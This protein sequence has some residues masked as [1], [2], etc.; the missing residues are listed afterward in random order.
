MIGTDHENIA[1]IFIIL[2]QFVICRYLGE[3]ILLYLEYIF[4]MYSWILTLAMEYNPKVRNKSC[5]H[6]LTCLRAQ[7]NKEIADPP[8]PTAEIEIKFF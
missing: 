4:D 8:S 6:V 2:A 7:F 1:Y 5:N 3:N